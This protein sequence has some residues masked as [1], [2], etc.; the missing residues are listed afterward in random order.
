MRR[1]TLAH[2]L[3]KRVGFRRSVTLLRFVW[4]WALFVEVEKR[5]PE[6]IDEFAEAFGV[7]RA[8]AYRWQSFLREAYPEAETP[9]WVLGRLR[10][11]A[12]Q[13]TM[14]EFGQARWA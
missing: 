6:N 8:T 7:D 2:D 3:Q 9:A 11:P 14:R 4:L 1:D 10:K 12:K 5:D 13:V